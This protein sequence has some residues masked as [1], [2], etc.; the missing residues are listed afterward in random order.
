MPARAHTLTHTLDSA[1]RVKTEHRVTTNAAFL[2]RQGWGLCEDCVQAPV[3]SV[4][5]HKRSSNPTH[6]SWLTSNQNRP[7]KYHK[8]D[9]IISK[10]SGAT[11]KTVQ[12]EQ[13]EHVYKEM[14][15]QKLPFVWNNHVRGRNH[16]MKSKQARDSTVSETEG[17]N[18]FPPHLKLMKTK[19]KVDVLCCGS[20]TEQK[21]IPSNWS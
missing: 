20:T 2:C 12:Y 19:L 11:C 16:R 13:N 4:G 21:H 15:L 18:L 5:S 1:V 9:T 6:S 7:Y 10:K 8:S 17:E 14:F 3:Q